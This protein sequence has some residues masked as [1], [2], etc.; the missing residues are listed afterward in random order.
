MTIR[1]LHTP[2]VCEMNWSLLFFRAQLTLVS[3]LIV[4]VIMSMPL[5]AATDVQDPDMGTHDY[6]MDKQQSYNCSMVQMNDNELSD[7]TAAGFSSFTL[8]DKVT[9]AYFNL[10]TQTF[11]EIQS[12]KMGYYNN[13]STTGWDE[14][15]TG[16]KLGSATE[17]LVLKGLYVEAGFTDIANSSGARTLDY[18]KIGTQHMTGPISATFNSFSGRIED[19]FGN[20]VVFNGTTID[21]QRITTLGT[22][23]IYSNNDEFYLQLNNKSVS[24]GGWWFFWKNA[25]VN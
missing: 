24:G 17:D 20:P 5:F 13:D 18:F 25:S 11:T 19:G 8:T 14:D 23:T 21:G 15:W 1:C 22:R 7:V 6:I 4:L 3:T 9:R 2:G 12:L 10:E 16:V